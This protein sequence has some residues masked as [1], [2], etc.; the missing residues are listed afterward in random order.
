M[1]VRYRWMFDARLHLLIIMVGIGALTSLFNRPEPDDP[2]NSALVIEAPWLDDP[3]LQALA[4]GATLENAG[5]M[6]RAQRASDDPASGA[7]VR[8]T[9]AP[10]E[11]AMLRT[12]KVATP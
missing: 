4:S 6:A 11:F 3:A 5:E 9:F 10:H 8:E 1:K 7:R 12:K 2:F